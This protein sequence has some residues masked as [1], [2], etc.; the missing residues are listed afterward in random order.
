[1]MSIGFSVCFENK[2]VSIY[3]GTIFYGC[4]YLSDDFL[5]LYV[6]DSSLNKNANGSISNIASF[7]DNDSMRWR[8]RLGHIGK[9]G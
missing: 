1:M 4:G 5:V 3:L 8:A 2:G 9:T 7:C 6:D